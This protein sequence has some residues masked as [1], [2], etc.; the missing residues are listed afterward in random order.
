MT[1]QNGKRVQN[2]RVIVPRPDRVRQ[3]GHSSFGWLDAR[4]QRLSL[5]HI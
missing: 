4:L 5:I 3:I 2:Q 1:R